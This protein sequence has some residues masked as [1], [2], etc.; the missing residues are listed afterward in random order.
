MRAIKNIEFKILCGTNEDKETRRD[1]LSVV[2]IDE[3][4]FVA[5]FLHFTN[6]LLMKWTE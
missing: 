2:P 5:C 1:Y 3:M 6:P 4:A